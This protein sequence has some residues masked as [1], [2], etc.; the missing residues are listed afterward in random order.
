MSGRRPALRDD[1]ERTWGGHDYLL[2]QGRPWEG[3]P[4][5]LDLDVQHQGTTDAVPAAGPQCPVK[6]PELPDAGVASLD[7]PG[8]WEGGGADPL[9]TQDDNARRWALRAES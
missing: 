1:P 2:A 8:N 3:P 5:P 6:G 4:P 9:D 7:P